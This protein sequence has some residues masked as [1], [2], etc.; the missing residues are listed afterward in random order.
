MKRS[1][2]QHSIEEQDRDFTSM[3]VSGV[4]NASRDNRQKKVSS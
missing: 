3:W 2:G 4:L 1:N